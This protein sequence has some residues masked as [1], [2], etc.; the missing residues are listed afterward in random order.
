MIRASGANIVWI[1]LGSPKQDVWIAR[2][3]KKLPACVLIASGATFDF[4][5]GRARQ[6]PRWIRNAGL[7]WLFRL[8]QDPVR[9]WKRYTIYNVLFAGA[10]ILEVLGLLRLGDEPEKRATA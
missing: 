9:L 7:E 6:A 1:G 3:R 5:S 8:F 10:L 2:H 4:F